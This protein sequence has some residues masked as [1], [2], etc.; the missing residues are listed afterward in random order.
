M[1]KI[2]AGAVLAASLAFTG[3]A[4]QAATT[5]TALTF[6][7]S[8]TSNIGN[9]FTSAGSFTDN[10]TFSYTAGTFDVSS[11]VISISLG[12]T[13]VLGVSSFSLTNTTTGAVY[14]STSSSAGSLQ[15]YTITASSL[16]SG[17]YVLSVK[18][19]V[20]GTSGG[21][22]GGNISVSAVPEASTTAMMLGGLALVGFVATRRRRSTTAPMN[23]NLMPA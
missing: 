22:Y 14:N 7:N 4:A 13:S 9:T 8:T 11:A 16:T 18:G 17:S 3:V 12:T 2:L 21:S 1:H 10:Y 5:T 6:N 15:Y 20:T 19:N 23:L